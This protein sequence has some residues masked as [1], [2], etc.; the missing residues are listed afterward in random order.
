MSAQTESDSSKH[1]QVS[2][3]IVLSGSVIT[4]GGDIVGGDKIVHAVDTTAIDKLFEPILSE[5]KQHVPP[6]KQAEAER[7]LVDIRE[8][9]KSY[10]PNLV[11]VGNALTWLKDNAPDV[12]P[13]LKALMRDPLLPSSIRDVAMLTFGSTK[14]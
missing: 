4:V 5:V 12:T 11:V 8:Q 14:E 10:P 7:R 6:D 13:Q 2:S 1:Q 3:G 9:A